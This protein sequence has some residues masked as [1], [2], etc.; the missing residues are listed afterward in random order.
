M[1]KSSTSNLVNLIN[2]FDEN[3]N[4]KLKHK[5][6]EFKKSFFQEFDFTNYKKYV[7][8]KDYIHI[9]EKYNEENLKAPG[10]S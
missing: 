2:K 3:L 5:K 4:S 1:R 8:Q 10:K 7:E 6:S 9:L